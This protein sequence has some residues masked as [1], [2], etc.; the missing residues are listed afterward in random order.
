MRCHLKFRE[1]DSVIGINS[2]EGRELK[3]V[4]GVVSLIDDTF[5]DTILYGVIWDLDVGG[6][7]LMG[8]CPYGRG[9]WVREDCIELHNLNLENK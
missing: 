1:G 2:Y 4:S 5:A 8:N 7:A 9:W 3:G 6:H